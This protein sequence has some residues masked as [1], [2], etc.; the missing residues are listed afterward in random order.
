[1]TRKMAIWLA[2]LTLM[3]CLTPERTERNL[4][5]AMAALDRT[6]IPA[7]T[8]T[9]IDSEENPVAA[10]QTLVKEW[11]YFKGRFY[12]Y[13]RLD[14]SWQATLD[15]AG[16]VLT[17]ADELVAGGDKFSAHMT[18]QSLR[19]I[20]V[21][22]RSSRE[23]DYYLDGLTA[24][25]EPMEA[26]VRI[27]RGKSASNLTNS[28]INA[29]RALFPEARTRWDTV[30]SQVFDA[31]LYRFSEERATRLQAQIALEDNALD[32]LEQALGSRA[33]N[34]IVV[35]AQGIEPEFIELY[36]LFGSS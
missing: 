27:V 18:L 5:G 13:E 28:D 25:Q 23:I 1:M 26:I 16:L 35:A 8:Q 32:I 6:F 34:S 20:L 14:T 19:N 12:W 3:A 4:V 17:Q 2:V 24:F 30:S 11:D 9:S 36:R 33:R 22:L 21:E 7:L 29:I 10:M 31:P 15:Q